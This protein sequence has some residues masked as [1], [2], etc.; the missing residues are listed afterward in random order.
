MIVCKW[1]RNIAD[2]N[3]FIFQYSILSSGSVSIGFSAAES[4]KV[5]LNGSV[6]GFSVVYNSF[7]KSDIS[8]ILKY[9]MNKN[10]IK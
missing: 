9:L 8:K 6:Y 2:N 3:N 4:R 1:K 5:S 7:D 10:N